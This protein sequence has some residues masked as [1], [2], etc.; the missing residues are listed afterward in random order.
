MD[1]D[2]VQGRREGDIEVVVVRAGARRGGK[3]AVNL[4]RKTNILALRNQLV[5]LVDLGSKNVEAWLVVAAFADKDI[6]MVDKVV[7]DNNFVS[8][9]RQA[10]ITALSNL[11]GLGK[12]V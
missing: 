4:A 2:H 8:L 9:G 10:E 12:R 1:L 7:E 5:F 6:N 3:L 11:F